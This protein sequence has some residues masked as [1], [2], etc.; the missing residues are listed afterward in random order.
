MA[1]AGPT[2]TPP[3]QMESAMNSAT[4]DPDR[5][6]EILVDIGPD[7]TLSP[8][9]TAALDELALALAAEE[10]A[11]VLD[12]LGDA[13]NEDEVVGFSLSRSLGDLGLSPQTTHICISKNTTGTGSCG[14]WCAIN[15]DQ[16]TRSCGIDIW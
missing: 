12:T 11:D 2:D 10:V 14:S 4:P 13:M 9:L 7:V 15:T 16:D 8:R 5:R 1:L 6:F 3:Y